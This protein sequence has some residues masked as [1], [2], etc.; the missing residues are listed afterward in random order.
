VLSRKRD[1][2]VDSFQRDLELK[3]DTIG[4]LQRLSSGVN[5]RWFQRVVGSLH[6]Q[7]PVLPVGL[8]EDRRNAAG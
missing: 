8:D 3:D 6:N 4:S 1:R 2:V 5:I 7:N